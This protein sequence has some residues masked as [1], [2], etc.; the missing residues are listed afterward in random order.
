[1]EEDYQPKGSL[2]AAREELPLLEGSSRFKTI[3]C[4]LMKF[5]FPAEAVAK[6]SGQGLFLC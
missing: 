1:M 6:G 4:K 5:L 2:S 3:Y